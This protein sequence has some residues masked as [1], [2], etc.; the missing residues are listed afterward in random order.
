MYT[1]YFEVFEQRTLVIFNFKLFV[2][3]MKLLTNSKDW[4]ESRLIISLPAY[5]SFIGRFPSVAQPSLDER[6]SA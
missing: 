4:S 5:L 6:K 3:S 2:D 1:N